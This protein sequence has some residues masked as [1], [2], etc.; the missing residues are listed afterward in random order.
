MEA[1]YV[2]IITKKKIVFIF[3]TVNTISFVLHSPS[4]QAFDL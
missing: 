2:I 4:L 1:V 3:D